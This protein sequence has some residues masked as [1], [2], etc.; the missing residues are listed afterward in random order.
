MP[1]PRLFASVGALLTTVALIT[2]CSGS[3]VPSSQQS[4]S[5]SSAVPVASAP[6]PTT[7]A[8]SPMPASDED[9]VRETVLAFQDAYNT[10]NWD[11]YFELMCPAWRA[12]YTGS[13]M[14]ATKKTRVDHGLSTVTVT[15]VNIEGDAA[16][17]TVDAQNELLGRKTLEFKLAREDGWKMCMPYGG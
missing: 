10:Q 16:T 9:Q 1:L 2:A 8:P 12:Q 5:S 4:S 7:A 6:A 15:A 11:A 3:V 13:V 17:A 14:E